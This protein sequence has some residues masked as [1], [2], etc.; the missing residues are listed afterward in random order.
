[1]G[2]QDRLN[3]YTCG[4]IQQFQIRN[5]VDALCRSVQVRLSQAGNG[6]A[7]VKLAE[8]E[9]HAHL[10]LSMTFG[11]C[12][13]TLSFC[14]QSKCAE[15]WPNTAGADKVRIYGDYEVILQRR[16]V[17]R[18]WVQSTMTLKHLDVSVWGA[19]VGCACGASRSCECKWG[20]GSVKEWVCA[21]VASVCVCGGG[22]A[23]A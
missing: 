16:E 20:G 3:R 9:G 14:P 21:C 18:T 8:R 7:G 12:A 17:T 6:G 4:Q 13:V 1:M 23:C 10:S 2:C 22:G 11:A 5:V 15:Y 19:W